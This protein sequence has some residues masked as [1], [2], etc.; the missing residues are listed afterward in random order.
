MTW[1]LLDAGEPRLAAAIPFYGPAPEAPDFG[2][3]TAAVM[4]VYAELDERVNA[5]QERVRA[6]LEAAGPEHN[7]KVLSGRGPCLLQRHGRSLRP[8]PGRRGMGG[9]DRLV[10]RAPAGTLER[11][12]RAP[13]RVAGGELTPSLLTGIGNRPAESKPVLGVG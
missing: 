13:G 11:T 3:D 2:G 10:R 5:S 8:D 6:A 12:A 7:F 1:L 9:C 4:G